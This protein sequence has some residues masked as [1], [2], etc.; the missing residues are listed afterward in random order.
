MWIYLLAGYPRPTVRWERVVSGGRVVLT[1]NDF[2]VNSKQTTDNQN[3]MSGEQWYTL[4]VRLGVCHVR[5]AMVHAQSMSGSLS[6]PGSSGTPSRYVWE[7][8]I[9][10]EQWYT[11]KVRLGVCHV[12]GAL[13]HPQGTSG[14]LSCPGSSGTPLR[15]IWESVMSGEQ[16]CT[17]KVCLAVFQSHLRRCLTFERNQ[18]FWKHLNLKSLF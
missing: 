12:R 7:S 18:Y 16:W 2:F 14:G 11:L 8:V 15:Y 17:H 5:G 3:L 4:K 10:G 9:S 6:Y 13:V 1:D